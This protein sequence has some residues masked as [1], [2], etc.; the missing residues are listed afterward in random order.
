MSGS[1]NMR[2]T[3]AFFRCV[4]AA[5]CLCSSVACD[6]LS[7]RLGIS[8]NS[9]T[10]P[11]ETS[12]ASAD[13]QTKSHRVDDSSR[14][15]PVAVGKT[16]PAE[17][18]QFNADYEKWK[19]RAVE[20]FPEIGIA[21]SRFNE[22]FLLE[23]KK[24]RE[25]NAPELLHPNWPYLLALQVNT[26]LEKQRRQS[27]ASGAQ[28]PAENVQPGSNAPAEQNDNPD[29][30]GNY[31]VADLPKLKTLPKGGLFKGTITR[32][33]KQIAAGDLDIV[34]ILDGI[35]LCE[36][37]LD[38]NANSVRTSNGF[39]APSFY[40]GGSSR[41]SNTLEII[42]DRNSLKLVEKQTTSQRSA[43]SGRTYTQTARS[44]LLTLSV[45][46]TVSVEG[47]LLLKANKKP[48]LKGIIR[49][50]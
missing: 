38:R 45:G 20:E 15:S 21:G 40:F 47:M 24:L 26:L 7:Q 49:E 22:L 5:A 32:L 36:I 42:E 30:F 46:Q 4:S 28:K 37:N 48:F 19:L 3:L 14:E 25:S 11:G 27:V 9:K 34:L 2:K 10:E 33:E 41:K 39:Y 35:L 13:A 12:G 50:D 44:D 29:R 16:E 8:Q 31:A 43:V 23:A 1:L 18:S 6:Q 17:A